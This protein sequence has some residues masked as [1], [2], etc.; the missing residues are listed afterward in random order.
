MKGE[1][2]S[3]RIPAEHEKKRRQLLGGVSIDMTSPTGFSLGFG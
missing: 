2:C 1:N 3:N